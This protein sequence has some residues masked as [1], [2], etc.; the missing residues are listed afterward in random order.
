MKYLLLLLLPFLIQSC[1]NGQPQSQE[2]TANT[3]INQAAEEGHYGS[4]L[5]A[6]KA[7][8]AS[9]LPDLLDRFS[10]KELKLNGEIT[11]SCKMT[12]CWMNLDIGD[13]ETV[14]ITFK[15]EAFEIP[16]D[17]AGKTATVEGVATKELIPVDYLKR[18]AKS[19][20]KTQQEIDAITEPVVEYSFVATGVVIEE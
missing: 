3:T 5:S 14:H 1:D 12:G 4:A 8:N 16:L 9:E 17:A 13:G 6:S 7:K 18:Q 10:S 2:Q 19:E 15:D 11:S 20:G